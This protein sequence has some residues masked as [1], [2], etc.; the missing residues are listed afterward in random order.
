M[1]TFIDK[2]GNCKLVSIPIQGKVSSTT[3]L[4]TGLRPGFS[5]RSKRRQSL[6]TYP[7]QDILVNPHPPSFLV[8]MGKYIKAFYMTTLGIQFTL[9]QCLNTAVA[10]L[11]ISYVHSVS[12]LETS[13]IRLILQLFISIPSLLYY[14]DPFWPNKTEFW[15]IM[16]RS[17]TS[18]VGI[19]CM[20]YSYAYMPISDANAVTRTSPIYVILLG[21]LFLPERVFPFDLVIIFVMLIGMILIT[22]PDFLFGILPGEAGKLWPQKNI[23]IAFSMS[24]AITI[25]I[26]M[27]SI[28]MARTP[29]ALNMFNFSV[30]G[31]AILVCVG[32]PLKLFVWPPCYG[33]DKWYLLGASICGALSQVFLY[34]SLK[35][36]NA[37]I[38]AAI[39][40][41]AILYSLLLQIIFLKQV[42][43]WNSWA[44]AAIIT[45]AIVGYG[46]RKWTMNREKGPMISKHIF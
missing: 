5:T 19:T 41:T 23:G 36:E 42:P 2:T 32:V 45:L 34:L 27:I 40:S 9:I 17:V 26:S 16:I 24:S 37:G 3:K 10:S 12:P 11:L 18:T 22:R 20:I 38:V 25:S 46:L 31:I 44:G 29:L 35:Y 7:A 14:G 33:P 43:M 28:K 6:L 13:L 15:P 8:R 21:R 39:N 4:S 1:E 30:V